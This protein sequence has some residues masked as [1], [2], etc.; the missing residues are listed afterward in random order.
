VRGSETPG[1]AL[2]GNL[3]S[4]G[5]IQTPQGEYVVACVLC[6]EQ[7]AVQLYPHRLDGFI[8]GWVFV[9]ARDA[10]ELAGADVHIVGRGRPISLGANPDA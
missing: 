6:R 5:Q 2:K 1:E 9:C 10:P 7:T 8:V 3:M 4:D